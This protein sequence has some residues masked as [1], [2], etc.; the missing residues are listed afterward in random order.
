VP[1]PPK[2]DA[3]VEAKAAEA[4]AA[5]KKKFKG[6]KASVGGGFDH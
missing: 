6:W 2:K 1:P 5:L 4:S 3:N